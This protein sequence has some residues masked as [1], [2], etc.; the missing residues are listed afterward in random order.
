M[1]KPHVNMGFCVFIILY[2][3]S[4][5]KSLLYMNKWLDQRRQNCYKNI[6][7]GMS[8]TGVLVLSEIV[9]K[10]NEKY[11]ENVDGFCK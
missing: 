7:Y 11:I 10:R 4:K 8:G 6:K 9:R 5:R 3:L 2:I 1:N